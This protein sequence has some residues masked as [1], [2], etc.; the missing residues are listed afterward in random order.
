M[1][2]II[3]RLVIAAIVLGS[4]PAWAAERA[5]PDQAIALVKKA[6]AYIGSAGRDKALTEISDK[7][8]QFVSGELYIFVYDLKGTCLAIG[9]GNAAKMVGKDLSD[10]RDANG[11]YIIKSF[12]ELLNTK[13]SGWVDYN[14]PNPVTK[15]VEL[16]S[17]YVEKVGDVL[18]G[19]GIYKAK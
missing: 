3:R 18:V 15:A 7:N 19:A 2:S 4:V 11:K 12:V 5:T 8:G 13:P 16:K 9:N 14:W 6:V 10:M 1:K 17:S